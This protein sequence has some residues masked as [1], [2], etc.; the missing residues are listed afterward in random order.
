M[1][2]LIDTWANSDGSNAHPS[3]PTLAEAS[4]HSVKWVEARLRELRKA[5]WLTIGKKETKCGR[6]NLYTLHYIDRTALPN[7]A[8]HRPRADEIAPQWENHRGSF[9]Q[10]YAQING[11]GSPPKRL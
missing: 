9:E 4:G 11:P 8:D 2:F 3:V 1:F 10:F 7:F 5:G 6:V